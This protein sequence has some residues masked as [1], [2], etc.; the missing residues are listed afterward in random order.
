MSFDWGARDSFGR[1]RDRHFPIRN[2]T[3]SSGKVRGR[4]FTLRSRK[5]LPGEPYD[6]AAG[7]ETGPESKFGGRGGGNRFCR[8]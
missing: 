2:V 3:S 4:N 1:I 5:Q 8:F 6:D 7:E